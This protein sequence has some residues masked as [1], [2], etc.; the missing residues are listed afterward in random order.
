MKPNTCLFVDVWEGQLEIDEATLRA[1]GVAGMAIRI[2]DMAGGHHLDKGFIKQW[3]E[4]VNF[5]RWPY[6]VY[7]PWVDGQA[8]FYW[9]AEFMPPSATA[10][11]VDIEVRFSGIRP[12]EY[13]QQVQKFISLCK[14]HWKVMIYTGYWFLPNMSSWP[15][16]IDYWWAQYPDPVSYFG[17]VRTWEDLKTALDRLDKPFNISNVPGPLKMWQFSGDYLLLPGTVRKIDV[18]IF[19]GDVDD[20]ARYIGTSAPNP[21]VDVT[22]QYY[23]VKDDLEAGVPPRPYIR[24]GL[25]ATVRLRGGKDFVRLPDKWMEYV[26]SI[27]TAAAYNYIFKPASGWHN[28]GDLCRVEQVTFAGNILDVTRIEGN[29]AYIRSFDVGSDPPASPI[30]PNVSNLHPLVQLFTTQYLRWLDMTTNGRYPRVLIV[31]NPGEELWI[32]IGE[33]RPY[34]PQNRLVII[35]AIP[36]LNVRSAPTATA[37]IV[38]RLFINA[39]VTVVETVWAGSNIWG[40]IDGGWIALKYN[41]VYHTDWKI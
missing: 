18:N 11:A 40:K 15:T 23:R 39:R 5:V 3:D 41:G 9:L 34:K 22:H 13:A 24:D 2:N 28:Q 26:R 33:I 30:M 10:V 21:P 16:N 32:D 29:R 12:A 37:A 8:N 27:N 17:G 20:L 7:N 1:A 25:P 35:K 36:Y 19:Y 31:S 14:P 38:D 6:F 4:A